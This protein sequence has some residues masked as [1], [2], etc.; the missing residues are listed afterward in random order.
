VVEDERSQ[1]A[2]EDVVDH[3]EFAPAD[4]GS[5]V[6]RGDGDGEKWAREVGRGRGTWD[7][8]IVRW[9]SGEV[10]EVSIFDGI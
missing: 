10:H 3:G 9:A 7:E 1:E 8:L 5:G 2:W 6:R 4:S